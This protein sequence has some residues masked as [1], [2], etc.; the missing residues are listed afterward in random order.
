MIAVL[1][2]ASVCGCGSPATAP[3][4]T[5]P[6][7]SRPQ[8]TPLASSG[9]RG[10]ER[11]QQTAWSVVRALSRAG[12]AATNPLDTTA[13]ECPSAGCRESV[14]TDQLRVKSFASASQASRYAAAHD[15]QSSGPIVVS[16]APPLPANAREKYWAA[17]VRF[18]GAST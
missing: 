9:A 18:T 14:V 4:S 8:G 13:Q 15:L 12:L 1:V 10:G 5:Q 7:V 3:P 2:T 11:S 6:G 16:F 17:V